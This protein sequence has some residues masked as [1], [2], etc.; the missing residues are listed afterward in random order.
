MR[1]KEFDM[2]SKM[3]TMTIAG[4]VGLMGLASVPAQADSFSLGFGARGDDVR[5]GIRVSD[6]G[7]RYAR[8]W[9]RRCTPD[10]ALVKA[11]R[12]GVRRARIQSVHPRRISVVGRKH[13][14]RIRVVFARAPGCPVVG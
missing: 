14:D 2:L 9:D 6:E 13:G 1:Q 8:D 12:M 5:V 10:R 3:K 4:L 7:P 11:E